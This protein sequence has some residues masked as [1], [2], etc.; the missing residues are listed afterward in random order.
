MPEQPRSRV[1]IA[2][3]A[4]LEALIM[5]G[6]TTFIETYKGLAERPAG[7]EEQYGFETFNE[8]KLRPDLS[9]S[10]NALSRH[11]S[12][13]DSPRAVTSPAHS[14][15]ILYLL[16]EAAGKPAGFAKLDFQSCHSLITDPNALLLSKLYL[17]REFQGQ[18]LGKALMQAVDTCGLERGC[19]GQWLSVWDMNQSAIRFYERAGFRVVGQ[20]PWTFQVGDVRFEDNDF[21][22]YR[23]LRRMPEKTLAGSGE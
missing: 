23:E 2:S 11:A 9:A 13:P 1:R 15:R 19:T 6:R 22:M 20:S 16:A 12:S 3:L 17:L 7:L 21:V 18:G 14:P 5:L 4:D 8:E 10:P